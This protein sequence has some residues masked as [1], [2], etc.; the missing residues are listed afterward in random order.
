MGNI[1]RFPVVGGLNPAVF[2]LEIKNRGGAT[3]GD[4]VVF[5]IVPGAASAIELS[6]ATLT[7]VE[8]RGISPFQIFR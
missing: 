1:V 2:E 8:Q 4:A 7:L 3:S 6:G 5:S